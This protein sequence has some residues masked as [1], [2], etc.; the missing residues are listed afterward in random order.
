MVDMLKAGKR[1]VFL[2]AD[3]IKEWDQLDELMA[4]AAEG[5]IGPYLAGVKLNDALQGIPGFSGSDTVQGIMDSFPRLTHVFVDLKLADVMDTD[6]NTIRHFY[7]PWGEEQDFPQIIAT[8]SLHSAPK[9]FVGLANAFPQLHVAGMGVP[10]DWTAEQCVQRYG[11]PPF[12]CMENWLRDLDETFPNLKDAPEGRHPV[13]YA[14]ASAEMLE[15]MNDRFPWVS[16]ITPGIRDEWMLKGNQER[17]GGVAYALAT[18]AKF[19]VMGAQL[20]RG[21]PEAGIDAE[22]SQKRT[23]DLI[24][25]ALAA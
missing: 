10:T 15:M 8:V 17:I 4:T 24:E 14:I 16:C 22:E 18:G 23:A 12:E 1:C 19:V 6:V 20:T 25:E 7:E 21:N 13:E 2:A 11:M 3:K 9:V 5:P